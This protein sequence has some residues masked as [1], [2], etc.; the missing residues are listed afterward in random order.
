MPV[1][2]ADDGDWFITDSFEFL[3]RAV[4][5]S[6]KAA[7]A[8][9]ADFPLDGQVNLLTTGAFDRPG[10]LLDFERTRGVA[11]FSLGAPVGDHGDWSVRAAMNQ[12]DLD[13]WI[14]AGNYAVRAGTPHR[15]QF[16]SSY[17]VQHYQGGNVA[18]RASMQETARNVGSMYVFDEWAISPVFSV[19]AGANYGHYDYLAAPSLFS[20]Q[21]TATLTPHRGYR[22]RAVAL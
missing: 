8:L 5:S 16:G 6:A 3:G 2:P 10:E 19:G 20:P 12:S 14:V 13:S 11:F 22:V 4:G 9:I 17:S 7:G 15:Y 18:A 1:M 21:L